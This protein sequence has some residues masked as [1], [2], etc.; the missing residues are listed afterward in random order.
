MV[1]SCEQLVD[2]VRSE[3]IPHFG[4]I[5]GDADHTMAYRLVIGDVGELETRHRI[6][7]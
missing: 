5:E 2:C 3:G 7:R 1:E 6:P 4:P